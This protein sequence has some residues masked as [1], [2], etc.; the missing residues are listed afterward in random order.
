MYGTVESYDAYYF[1]LVSGY[2]V[3]VDARMVSTHDGET[4]MRGQGSRYSLNVCR[5]SIPRTSPS[6]RP[7]RY[8][9][10]ATSNWPAPK[11]KS[12]ANW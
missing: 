10:S 4:L 9:S 3:G 1:A 6:T 11:K 8:C 12:R 5:R 2:V 7:N